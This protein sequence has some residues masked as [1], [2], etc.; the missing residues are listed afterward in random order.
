MGLE[1]LKIDNKIIKK[2]VKDYITGLVWCL[3]YYLDECKSWSW[4]YNFM[5]GPLIQDII[6][7]YPKIH[8]NYIG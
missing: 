2:M 4:G 8:L 5:V 3:N 6:N 7:Y 1:E